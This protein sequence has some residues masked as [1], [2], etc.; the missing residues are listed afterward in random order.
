MRRS[1]TLRGLLVF[2]FALPFATAA[3]GSGRGA[4]TEVHHAER[5]Q[6][7]TATTAN[8]N[9]D[10]FAGAVRDL[11]K[12]EPRER[13]ARLSG[14]VARQMTR[15]ATRYKERDRDRATAS[16]SGAMFLVRTGELT[17][18]MFG[19]N[20]YAAL[21]AASEEFARRGD[22]GRARATYELLS[23]IASPEEKADIKGHLDAIV[24][25][26]RDTGGEGPMQTA[27][28]LEAAAVTRHLL[29]PSSDARNDAVA[30]TT[31]FINAA[32]ALRAARQGP[33]GGIQQITREEGMEAVRALET[34]TTVLAAI[35]LRDADPRGAIKAIDSANAHEITRPELIASLEAVANKPDSS[36][37]L[38][39]ARMFQPPQDRTRGDDED[40]GRDADLFRVASFVAASEAYRLDTTSPEPAAFV[41]A[42][43]VEMGMSDAA[44]AVLADAV[45]AQRDP[46]IVDVSLTITMQAMGRGVDAEDFAGARR[47][48]VAAQPIL[49]VA[50]SVKNAEPSPAKIYAM[51]GEIEIREARLPE[52]RKLLAAAAAREKNG[53]VLLSLA[54]LDGHDGQVKAAQ[55]KLHDALTASDVNKDVALRGEI[56]LLQSDIA[57]EL[58]DANAA[59]K[60]L[61]D[62][63]KNL[64]AARSATRGDERA[65]VERL[66][67]RALDRFGA[68]ASALKALERALEAAP[69]DKLQSAATIGQIVGRAFV[70]GD[71][72]G[73]R[74]GLARAAV[75]ELARED[76]IYYALW[77]RL[78]ERQMH[79]KN[80]GA[81]DRL[82]AQAADDPRWI[83]KIAAYGAGKLSAAALVAAAQTPAQK[84]ESLFYSAM[85]RRIAGD[86]KGADAAL[87][88]VV[89]SPGLDLM[90]VALAREILSG[91]RAE[92][93]GPVPEV[94]LP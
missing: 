42:M 76:I 27:G 44:P 38:D 90:E 53:A 17:S 13:S 55:E 67:A 25:W 83:G 57:R 87:R 82:L 80:D 50:D 89:E 18:E 86:T 46:R 35:F 6:I 56:L 78:L 31:S 1:L 5:A 15:V 58:G 40:L 84:T 62:A 26:T 66:I 4:G 63:L 41:A 70:K 20:G 81:A 85:E 45:R 14:V 33:Q 60:F 22:S 2:V 21:R 51:M 93:G 88:Q 65:R 61:A 69:R 24:A 39:L 52:A 36:K 8:V 68:G 91:P 10:A 30:K 94:G 48:F 32:T 28:T 59:R 77:V 11:L 79:V 73:A 75:A 37:W 16:L 19:P 74:E 47:T 9:D 7:P 43:L 34:G 23:R 92:I 72:A 64:A 12:S 29:E 3:C 71:L 49:S 54:R